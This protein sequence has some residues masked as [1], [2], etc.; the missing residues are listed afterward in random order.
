MNRA[1]KRRQ[2][3]SS[4]K[5]ARNSKPVLAADSSP[6]QQTLTIQRAME[7]AVQHHS[8]GRLAE[9]EGIYR[10]VLQADPLQPVA[11]QMLGVLSHQLGKS[12]V[13]IDLITKALA[14]EPDCAEAHYNLGVLLK[15]LGRLDEV[16]ASYRKALAIKPDYAEA[17]NNLGVALKE[18][19]K[20]D[21]A[22]ASYLKALA[23]APGI[24]ET[25]NNLGAVFQDLGRLDEA[26]ASYDKAIAIQPDYAAALIN[27]G[28]L[29][30]ELEKPDESIVN[31]QRALAISPANA[32][33]HNNLGAAFKK[34]GKLDEAVASHNEALVIAP[35][36]AEAHNNLGAALQALGR[37]EEAVASY[38]KALAIKPDYA[39]THNNLGAALQHLGRLEEAVAS[40]HKAIA[41]KPDYAEA[42]NNL[43]AALQD[44]GKPD[45]AVASHQNALAISPGYAEA[46]YNLGAGLKELGRPDEVIA[47]YRKALAI[48]PDYAD[49]HYNLGIAL[50]D[51]AEHREAVF[52]LRRSFVGQTGIQ[53]VGDEELSP[54]TTSLFLE[55]TNKC[56]FHC[57]FCPSDSQTRAIGFMDLEFAKKAIEEVAEKKLARRIAL[58]LMGEPTLHP[59]LIEILKF[60]ASKN[61][62]IDLVTNGSTLV[63]KVVP[64]ILDSLQ[65]TIEASHMT[66]TEETYHFRGDVGLS[67][68]RY[69]GNIRLLVREYMKRLANGGRIRNRIDIRV[70]VTMGTAS[71][72]DIIGSS[73]MARAIVTEWRD[74][75]AE[76][77]RE[78]DMAPFKRRDLNAND[79]SLD[80]EHMPMTYR[81]QRG[82]DLTLWKAFT[83]ANSRV[84][85]EYALQEV[86]EAVYCPNPFKQFAVLWNGDVSLCC[87]DYDGQLKVGNI[88]DDSI[89]SVMQGEAARNVRASMLG[90]RPLPP[91]CRTCQARPVKTEE[92]FNKVTI[93]SDVSPVFNIASLR[94]SEESTMPPLRPQSSAIES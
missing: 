11:L 42:H 52:H 58:H 65:G 15:D 45:E 85:D 2:R 29:L 55:L 36:L 43:G 32:D 10:Q 77:E 87:L 63:P 82:I 64:R 75:T 59:N 70:M 20:P 44:L 25:H 31:Y 3:K 56:N 28:D 26:I 94:G 13:A 88:R 69:I 38:D 16:V 68:K 71:N 86:E 12:D 90:Q 81:L 62:E 54:A 14:I 8:T 46:H 79:L 93:P 72:V 51:M 83:F 78:L 27:L 1:E 80:A 47:S 7:L 35:N 74:F 21:A 17:H 49:A 60:A 39:E 6:G 48:R 18:L 5:A 89:E 22:V 76:T 61:I 23:I 30:Q 4:Q 67:W 34:L 91:V 66:P 41:L 57:D 24:A 73:E 40:Y 92:V 84:S 37:V 50:G 9:A 53:P 33:V 19:G